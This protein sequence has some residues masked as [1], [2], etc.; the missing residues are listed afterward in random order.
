MECMM[1]DSVA[2]ASKSSS[3]RRYYPSVYLPENEVTVATFVLA[4]QLVLSC[5]AA[6]FQYVRR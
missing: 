4:T 1:I 5:C 6:P 2:G 3:D